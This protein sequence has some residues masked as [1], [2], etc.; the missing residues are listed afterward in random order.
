[1]TRNGNST[2]PAHMPTATTNSV[3]TTRKVSRWRL[4]PSVMCSYV[5]LSSSEVKYPP[6][7]TAGCAAVS[8]LQLRP[9]P[10]RSQ[11]THVTC[12]ER[13]PAQGESTANVAGR[14]ARYAHEKRPNLP[15]PSPVPRVTHTTRGGPD[16]APPRS[17]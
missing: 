7:Q 13:F 3:H 16:V 2:R 8:S 15:C 9:S 10:R 11:V 5:Q 4:Q 17:T 14:R 12:A 1:A 6:Q